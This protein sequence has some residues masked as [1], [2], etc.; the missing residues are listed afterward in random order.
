MVHLPDPGI[1]PAAR[2]KNDDKLIAYSVA[3]F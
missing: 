2:Q 3:G 1:D